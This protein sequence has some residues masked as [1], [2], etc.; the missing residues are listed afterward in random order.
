MAEY[1][2]YMHIERLEKEECDGLLQNNPV[3][4]T[5]KVDGTNC[6][7]WY[8]GEK[9]CGGSRTRQL[10]QSSDNAG[11]YTWLTSGSKEAGA[12]RQVVVEHPN[13]IIY[14]EW[15]GLKKFIG[16]IKSYDSIAKGHMYIF[17]VYDTDANHYLADPT[18]REALRD[19]NLEPY[20]V[21]LLA[22]LNHPTYDD[23][24]EIAKANNFLLTYAECV[25]EGVVCKAPDFRN[26]W[27]HNVY[28]KIVLDEFKQRKEQSRKKKD[29]ITREGIETDIVDYWVT[30]AEMAKAKAKV[31]IALG[32]DEFDKKSGKFIGFFLEMIWKDLLE[33]MSAICKQY[34]NPIIDFRILRNASNAKGRQ[35]LGLI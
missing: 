21:E 29:P 10:S 31:C 7:I 6:V 28:G 24:V 8:D 11:F 35:F 19:Y 27:G 18:W 26:K 22:V 4:V 15:L 17:D 23:I 2:K 13:W 5:A 33:E 14:G 20:Y 34:K 1:R 32:A 9:V 16:Q 3:Y 25:G 30:E 12:L